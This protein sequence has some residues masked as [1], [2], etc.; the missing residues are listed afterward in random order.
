MET[1]P[2]W[3]PIFVGFGEITV[4]TTQDGVTTIV[5]KPVASGD[6]IRWRVV[7][8]GAAVPVKMP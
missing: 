6:M 8:D 7:V 3:C 5:C 2:E 1:K 4:T